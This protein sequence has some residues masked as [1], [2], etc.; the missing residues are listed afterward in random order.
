MIVHPATPTA[1]PP[2]TPWRH[3]AD[4]LK[5]SGPGPL[6][7]THLRRYRRMHLGA[8]FDPGTLRAHSTG[9]LVPA[10][11]HRPPLMANAALTSGAVL[12]P[13]PPPHIVGIPPICCGLYQQLQLTADIGRGQ[14]GESRLTG[15]PSQSRSLGV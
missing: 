7:Q 3:A 13:A 12:G 5:C 8:G 14:H 6:G 1:W 2:A 15:T 11:H 10:A 4:L 9:S